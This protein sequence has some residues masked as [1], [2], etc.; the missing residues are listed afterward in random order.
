VLTIIVHHPLH[1]LG[2]F[3]VAGDE[4]ME[5][6]QYG[7]MPCG[8]GTDLGGDQFPSHKQLH[9]GTLLR[10]VGLYMPKLKINKHQIIL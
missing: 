1:L 5:L 3:I 4:W 6:Y 2:D 8:T 10:A 7:Y 9:S